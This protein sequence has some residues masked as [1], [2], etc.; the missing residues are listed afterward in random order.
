MV[1]VCRSVNAQ[2]SAGRAPYK[3]GNGDTG[4]YR[5]FRVDRAIRRRTPSRL[6]TMPPGADY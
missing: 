6:T 1:N 2:L 3:G 4:E 5:M